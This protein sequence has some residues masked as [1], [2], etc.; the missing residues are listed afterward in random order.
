MV[1]EK[2]PLL[3]YLAHLYLSFNDP[4]IMIGNFIADHVKGKA[5]ENYEGKI[6]K[7]IALHRAIDTFTD[8]HPVTI[9]SK[10]R[11]R[12]VFRK[13]APVIVDLYY[14]HFLGRD[15]S[16]YHHLVLADF[17]Q[18]SYALMQR[19]LTLLPERTVY[20]LGFME[21][22]NWLLKYATVDG[23]QRALTGLSRRTTF[24]SNMEHAHDF[25]REHYAEFEKE[26]EAFFPD[27]RLYVEAIGG[28]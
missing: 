23:L 3:N 25:L 18:H 10:E 15:W 1:Y 8:Q 19:H 16:R 7:G 13:Y 22:Q 24:E 14:D 6:R 20:M 11:L 21:S 9:K 4:E 27:L 26:F 17:A 2:L 5:V 28:V 12:P